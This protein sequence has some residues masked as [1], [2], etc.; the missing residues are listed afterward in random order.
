MDWLLRPERD[1]FRLLRWIA[2][3]LAVLGALSACLALLF[4][5]G[6]LIVSLL[7]GGAVGWSLFSFAYTL[8]LTCAGLTMCAA[9]HLLRA[10]ALLCA[11]RLQDRVAG[12]AAS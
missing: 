2:G 8:V 3:F 12:P 5:I 9:G 6:S 4:G 11:T 7:Q 10:L 1:D